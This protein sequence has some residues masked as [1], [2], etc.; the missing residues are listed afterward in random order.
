VD[1]LLG[2]VGRQSV[3]IITA[4]HAF[5]Q[6]LRLGHYD[7]ATDIPAWH[8]LRQAFDHPGT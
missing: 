4:G 7:I 1:P 5:V 2:E 6:N 8:R 3:R